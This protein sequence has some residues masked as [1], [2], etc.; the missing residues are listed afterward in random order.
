MDVPAALDHQPLD[1]AV[2]EIAGHPVHLHRVASVDNRRD[3]LEP[4]ASLDDRWTRAVDELLGVSGC[5]EVG[6]GVELGPAAHGHL[7]RSGCQAAG[8]PLVAALL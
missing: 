3:R 8:K 7:H 5:E 4:C 2:G 1:S 6:L